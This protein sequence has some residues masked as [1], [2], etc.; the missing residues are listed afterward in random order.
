METRAFQPVYV[1]TNFSGSVPGSLLPSVSVSAGTTAVSGQ[2]PFADN[3]NQIQ[4]FNGS[5]TGTA[6]LN[7]GDSSSLPAATV[8]TGYAVPPGG[9]FIITL[10]TEVSW[11]SVILSAGTGLVTFTRGE[12]L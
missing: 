6:Y 5:T 11:G 7:F 9:A 1:K 2:L 10:S 3:A 8:A 12:G 4:I